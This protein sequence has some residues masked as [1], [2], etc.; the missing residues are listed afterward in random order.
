MGWGSSACRSPR[1][2]FASSGPGRA[3]LAL[4]LV[5][6]LAAVLLAASCLRPPEGP[7]G[8]AQESGG[9]GGEGSPAPGYEDLLAT[10]AAEEL[11]GRLVVYFLD[12]GQADASFVRTPGG[13]VIVIDTGDSPDDVV[14]F[15]R[16]KG[17]ERVDVLVLS[18]PHADHIGGALRILEE[19]EVGVLYDS[20]FVHPTWVYEETLAKALELR[21]AGRL[22]YVAARAGQVLEVDPSVSV[23]VLHPE[24]PL[25]D[26]ANDASV[27]LKMVFGS[28]SVLFTGDIE[29]AGERAA[30]AR[31]AELGVDLGATVLK[32]AHH[33]S[34]TSTGPE[35]LEAV[36]PEVAVIQA[37]RDNPYGHPSPVVLR[38]LS[39]AGVTVYVTASH[40]TVIVH[41]DGEDWEV[42]TGH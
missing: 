42:V 12:V 13:K 16:A 17:V 2:R 32:V 1:Q 5:G 24:E 36:H 40:G 37:G 31:S 19:F 10:P 34:R 28:F 8:A 30:L 18:H 9:A 14:G 38:R 39:E 29:E 23:T 22:T 25:G 27:V 6:V 20:G 11:P 21:D 4:V 35:F 3:A 33:G 26:E 7:D 41:S 15:L